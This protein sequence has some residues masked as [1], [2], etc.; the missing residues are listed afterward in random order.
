MTAVDKVP[1]DPRLRLYRFVFEHVRDATIVFDADGRPILLNRAAR[2]L[3]SDFVEDLF[4]PGSP[5]AG[6]IGPFREDLASRGQAHA[7]I[8]AA[9]RA[10][11]VD[12]RA[13]GE[14]TVVTIRDL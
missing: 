9:G 4:S 1:S 7:E 14:Q 13:H 2:D 6:E 12:G 5:Y 11:V 10:L 8:R 3:A